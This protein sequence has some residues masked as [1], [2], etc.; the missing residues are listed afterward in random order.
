M[1]RTTECHARQ[2]NRGGGFPDRL[3]STPG[4]VITHLLPSASRYSVSFTSLT[5]VGDGQAWARVAVRY[6]LQRTCSF[7]LKI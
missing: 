5:P 4:T 6:Q 3:F 1:G 2:V 7:Q